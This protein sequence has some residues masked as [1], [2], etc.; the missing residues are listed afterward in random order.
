MDYITDWAQVIMVC[1]CFL[2]TGDTSVPSFQMEQGFRNI[3]FNC[4]NPECKNTF[5][6]DIKVR[7]VELLNTYYK[8]HQT[9]EGFYKYVERKKE[10]VRLRYIQNTNNTK[11]NP[12]VIIEV[13]NITRCPGYKLTENKHS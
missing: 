12:F 1:P 13:A 3:S 6:Y 4:K 5:D 7:L 11:Q 10:R 9:L 2:E 8:E